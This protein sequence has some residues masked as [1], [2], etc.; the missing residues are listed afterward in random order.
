MYKRHKLIIAN[1]SSTFRADICRTSKRSSQADRPLLDS[2]MDSKAAVQ[3]SA[4]FWTQ[5]PVPPE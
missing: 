4:R 5:Q 3:F 2:G 1:V